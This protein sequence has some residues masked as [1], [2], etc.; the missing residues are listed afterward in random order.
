M[1]FEIYE[2]EWTLLDTLFETLLIMAKNIYKQVIEN[3]SDNFRGYAA[4][5]RK[6]KQRAIYAA[7]EKC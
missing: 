5:L 3:M 6:I 1:L 7:N 4:L 2:L